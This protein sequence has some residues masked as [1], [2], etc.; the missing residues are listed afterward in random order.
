L[1]AIHNS[2][3]LIVVQSRDLLAQWNIG[4]VEQV[5]LP[6]PWLGAS[7]VVLGAGF[8]V[9]RLARKSVHMQSKEVV[10]L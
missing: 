4:Q 9:A 10:P 1:H 3:L 7:A 8:L 6:W 2:T 5:H